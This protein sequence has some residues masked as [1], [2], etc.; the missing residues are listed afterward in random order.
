MAGTGTFS[1]IVNAPEFP[2]GL[3]WLNVRRPLRLAELRG[4][5]VLLDFWS[6]CCINCMHVLPELRQLETK[7]EQEL[8]VIGVHSGKF[9]NE[10][11][12][13]QIRKAIIRYQIRHPVVNDADYQVWQAYAVEAWPTLVLINPLGK[14][15]A[16]SAGE[17]VFEPYDALLREA[18]P[19]FEARQQLKR[20]L[21]AFKLEEEPADAPLRFPGKVA[22]D[23]KR[24]RLFISDSNHHRI[25]VSDAAGKILE[26]IGSGLPG[27]EDG[28]FEKASFRH[29]QG[30]FADGD[31]LYIADTE[32]HLIRTAD[33][34]S[35]TVQTPLGTGAQARRFNQPGR[36]RSVALNSP[37][38]LLALDGKLYIA[39]AGS[40][41]LWVADLKSWEAR[42]FAGSG[43]E[44]LLDGP[45]MEAALAQPSGLAAGD[46][47]IYL[48]DSES[49]SIREVALKS[50]GA[51]KTLV[52]KGLFEFGDR[53]GPAHRALLQH[54]LGVSLRDG[55]LY[56]ADTYNNK[57]KML[58]LAAGIVKTLAGT[59]R[60]QFKDGRFAEAAFNEPGGLAW[61]AGKL[62]VADTNNHQIRVLDP[63]SQTVTTLKL[64]DGLLPRRAQ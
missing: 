25:L 42:P 62:Y 23:E 64:T 60:K 44:A 22:S 46:G 57:I 3:P 50:A 61:L 35:R 20:G 40:H 38:D 49:S 53:E 19:Y 4:K 6:Y 33:L 17:G 1:G 52:G 51:V 18:V 41:Q 21:P 5:F 39:M 9:S 45:P 59:G 48:A 30:V 26:V 11:D 13:E 55:V 28:N 63:T 16:R 56:I 10:R 12:T 8:V 58:D 14:I 54:P 31:R 32:N 43:R 37:W 15:I 36:G 2:E 47:K 24:G 29:P 7:Y 34:N 27:A